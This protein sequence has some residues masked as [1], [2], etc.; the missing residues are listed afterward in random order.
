MK[1]LMPNQDEIFVCRCELRIVSDA[2]SFFIETILKHHGVLNCFSKITANPS[3]VNEEG[4]LIICP[5]HDYLK[6]SHGCNLCPP[7]MCK[8]IALPLK[9]IYL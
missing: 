3:Y 7:N 2:N 6:S 8:A 4:R 1:I 9:S 5:Y